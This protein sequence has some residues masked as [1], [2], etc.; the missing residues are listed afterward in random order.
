MRAI[1]NQV[2]GSADELR[3]E[4]VA[5]PTMDAEDLVL[6]RVRAASVNALDWHIMRGLPYLVR[7]SEGLRGPKRSTRGVDVSGVVVAA[8]SGVKRF[9][10]GDEVF[11]TAA[12]SFAGFSTA[13]EANLAKKPPNLTFEQAA[14]I[15][16]AGCTALQALRD[17]GRL[18]PGQR[19]LI[20]G[21]GGGVGSFAVQVARALGASHVTGVCSTSKVDLVRSIGA[22][23]VFDYTRQDVGVASGPFDLIV[24]IAG[25]R[26][27]G[28]LRRLLT[29]KGTLVIAGGDSTG[30]WL[31][32]LARSL[33]AAALSPFVRQTLR[34]M[35][36][37]ICADDLDFLGAAAGAG[38][39]TPV[40]SATHPLEEAPAA[41][42]E[43]EAGHTTGKIVISVDQ[44]G[45]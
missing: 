22:D 9:R 5:V 36:A 8:G 41:I 26:P 15:P 18:R 28:A 23:E 14:A 10:P 13:K 45:S 37:T 20:T 44:S 30:R 29:P 39:V 34:S 16:V 1:V 6:I 11:G 43:V 21:A 27:I 12:G 19:V 2:Y 38:T 31:G 25:S 7:L 33:R 4:E 32:P 3:L 42:A 40:V 24:D 35:L 17:K